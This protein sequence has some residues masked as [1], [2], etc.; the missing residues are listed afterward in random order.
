MDVQTEAGHISPRCVLVLIDEEVHEQTLALSGAADLVRLD[1]FMIEREA[2][3]RHRIVV[4]HNI[5]SMA[6]KR[7]NKLQMQLLTVCR[8]TFLGMCTKRPSRSVAS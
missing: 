4:H 7:W 8:T 6:R 2:V 3:A 1:I 5:V